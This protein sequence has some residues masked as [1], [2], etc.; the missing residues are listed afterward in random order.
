MTDLIK[1]IGQVGVAS[2]DPVRLI[3]FYR[4]VL[5]CPVLFEAAGMTFLAAGATRLMICAAQDGATVAS[6]VFLYFEP[7]DWNALEARLAAAGVVFA[8]ET[9]IVQ[10]EPGREN[11]LRFF[12]DPDG[13]K[14]ALLGWRPSADA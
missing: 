2:A 8:H 12:T 4:D 11:A 9:Q 6:D 10:R 5:G 1:A 14:I 7:S 13:R 3:A